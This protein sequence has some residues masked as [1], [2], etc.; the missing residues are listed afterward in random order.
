MLYHISVLYFFLLLNISLHGCTTLLFI[1]SLVD[2][3]L[4]CLS[5]RVLQIMLLCI[6][7]YNL[8][9]G[10]MF[11]F[12]FF[13]LS[14]NEILLDQGISTLHSKHGNVFLKTFPNFWTSFF[15]SYI[16]PNSPLNIHSGNDLKFTHIKL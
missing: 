5:F 6:F 15:V 12:H 13:W 14:W 7:V 4:G 10:N 2:E 11:S 1:H 9:C 3:H 16:L 8:L